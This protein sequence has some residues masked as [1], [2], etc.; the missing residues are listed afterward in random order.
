MEGWVGGEKDGRNNGCKNEWREGWMD[1]CMNECIHACGHTWSHSEVTYLG[2]K[3][4][5]S[6]SLQNVLVT[7]PALS[8]PCRPALGL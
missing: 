5:S 6:S 8:P 1:A 3:P 2:P 7:R 4:Y